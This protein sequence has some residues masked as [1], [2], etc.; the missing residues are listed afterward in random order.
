MKPV[1]QKYQSMYADGHFTL[2][3]QTL[4]D[5]DINIKTLDFYDHQMQE[6]FAI[7]IGHSWSI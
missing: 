7:G 6:C 1:A 5:L 4:Q 2:T 3:P